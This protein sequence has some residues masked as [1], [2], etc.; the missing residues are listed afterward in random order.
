LTTKLHKTYK[1]GFKAFYDAYASDNRDQLRVDLREYESLL[2]KIFVK[3]H[4]IGVRETVRYVKAVRTQIYKVV[5]R[6]CQDETHIRLHKL[7]R[8][9]AVLGPKLGKAIYSGHEPT[10]RSVLTL[11]QVSYLLKEGKLSPNILPITEEGT[12]DDG[13]VKEISQ[14]VN[15]NYDRIFPRHFEVPEWS[16]PHMSTSAG[17]LGP[18]TW[19]IPEELN[20]LTPEI[21]EDLRTLGGEVFSDYLTSC[22]HQRETFQA[23]HDFL[24]KGSRFAHKS[25]NRTSLRRLA[26]IPAPECKTRIIGIL[27]WWSQTVLLPLHQFLFHQLAGNPNDL[28]FNQN[29]FNRVIPKNG[30]FYSFD[31]T[32]ATDRF[33]ISLQENVLTTLLGEK[34][35]KAWRRLLTGTPFT[36]SWDPTLAISYKCG[37]PMGA[38]S[39]WSVFA[40]THHFVVHYAASL[41][42]FIPGTFR[43]YVI[44]G[45]DIVIANSRVAGQYKAVMTLLG[46]K[47]SK[48]KSLSSSNSYEFAKRF[49]SNNR[50]MTAF[51]LAALI[52]NADSISAAWSVLS[53][54]R[55]RGFTCLTV[56]NT[57]SFL[58]S[59]QRASGTIFHHSA[60]IAKDL[61]SLQILTHPEDRSEDF[62]WAIYHLYK[63]F[64]LPKPCS[65]LKEYDKLVKIYLA[66]Q[67]LNYQTKLLNTA[68][69]H[70]DSL[71]REI[72]DEFFEFLSKEQ[73]RVE[74]TRAN[75]GQLSLLQ[76]Y[77]LLRILVIQVQNAMEENARIRTVVGM[78]SPIELLLLKVAP[79]GDLNR[80]VSRQV[81]LRRVAQ[82]AAF[83]KFL[84]TSTKGY[85]SIVAQQLS[86]P[87]EE[88]E[89]PY[90]L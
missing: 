5:S 51:P 17:P 63:T 85:L 34:K 84:R 18:A 12:S 47:I 35:S 9:P 59:I 20:L 74:S 1:E 73:E 67:V 4:H 60:R 81:N 58:L 38:Y 7:T 10:I 6:D 78:G 22:L 19:T 23:L 80:I 46:V 66:G 48:E 79:L 72:T 77:P 25:T 61:E 39:S 42:G 37:Q 11:L 8:L 88:E 52:E 28:T 14:F 57:P 16:D 64:D 24:S 62:V 45:D 43:A 82:Q 30:P 68:Q 89:N 27:D 54:A 40:L 86:E 50:E 65:S 69:V 83:V 33:P 41:E 36:T 75:T 15:L 3:I 13:I 55:E 31:L 44:L 87:Q 49:I 53:V 21:I 26:A 71:K 70:Y 90:L 2:T 76:D 56:Y 29:A 32:A